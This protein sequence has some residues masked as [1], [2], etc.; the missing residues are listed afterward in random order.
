MTTK[1]GVREITVTEPLLKTQ[2]RLGEGPVWDPQTQIL[3]FL[4]IHNCKVYHYH[5]ESGKLDV[6]TYDDK[7]G[8]IVLRP[9]RSKGLACAGR[10]GF[11]LLTKDP[12]TGKGTI[13]YLATP[14]PPSQEPYVRFNDG[15]CD[16]KGRFFAGTCHSDNPYVAGSLWRLDTDGSCECVD[17]DG[18]TDSNG[19]GWSP[20]DK[21]LYY[22]DSL[23][24]HIYAY[25]YDIDTGK[26]AN[27][28]V[29]IDTSAHGL[30][31]DSYPD[32]LCIDSEGGIWSARW[33]GSK[34]VRYGPD[35][36]PDII[37]HLPGAFNVTAC[38]FGGPNLDQLYITTGS[39]LCTGGDPNKVFDHEA[40]QQEFPQSGDLYVVDFKGQFKDGVWRHEY[41]G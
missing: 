12:E 28:R 8:C 16:R 37:I 5:P 4:D 14:L 32:G 29:H 34:V 15:A 3:H 36:T 9:D 41:L 7:I 1:S 17:D 30:G 33:N 6:D 23:T 11:G 2:C 25:D 18:I 26:I 13:K 38:C 31:N 21:I 35:G 20:D 19:L 24:N 22:T 10:R 27:R 39:A 40:K